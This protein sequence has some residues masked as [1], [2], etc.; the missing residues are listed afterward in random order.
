MTDKISLSL[1]HRLNMKLSGHLNPNDAAWK[2][3]I[4]NVLLH[5]LVV[6]LITFLS[7]YEFKS[8]LQFAFLI[9]LY[10]TTHPIHTEAVSSNVGRADVLCCLFFI[11]SF[12][13][14]SR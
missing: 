13:A 2:F 8:S 7:F 9:G 4:I 14:H 10:F 1:L 6:Q 3:R 12:I 5:T 11:I